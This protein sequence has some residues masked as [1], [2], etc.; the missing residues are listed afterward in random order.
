MRAQLGR[1]HVRANVLEQT[2]LSN[3]VADVRDV[4]KSDRSWSQNRRRHARQRGILS[5]ADRDPTLNGV[6]TANAKFFHA[7]RLKE[8]LKKGE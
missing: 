5:A 3:D 6:A 4:V 2:P 8:K 1:Q 7:R